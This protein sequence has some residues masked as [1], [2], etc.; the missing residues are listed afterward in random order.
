MLSENEKK[1]NL[2]IK[3]VAKTKTM[4]DWVANPD[5][6]K[7]QDDD[8]E[9]KLSE[10]PKSGAAAFLYPIYKALDWR[11]TVNMRSSNKIAK[12]WDKMK[13]FANWWC[14]EMKRP[15]YEKFTKKGNK[16]QY[17]MK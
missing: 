15:C 8:R 3:M 5:N 17:Q 11:M 14:N 6:T 7:S 4:W 12:I 2:D 13:I 9:E 10:V 1:L 16:W